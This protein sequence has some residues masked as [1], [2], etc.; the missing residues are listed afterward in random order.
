MGPRPAGVVALLISVCVQ[1]VGFNGRAWINEARVTHLYSQMADRFMHGHLT[2]GDVSGA[3]VL[4]PDPVWGN[5]L[6]DSSVYQGHFYYYWGPTPA[7]LLAGACRVLGLG[8][9]HVSDLD[10]SIAFGLATEACA[11]LLI[12]QIRA[13]FFPDQR[14][15][16]PAIMSLTL[17][18]PIL[19][20]LVYP[21]INQAAIFA[22]QFFVLAG[23]VAA[24][25][26]LGQDQ[27]RPGW[28]AAAG[29]S[30]SLAAGS[31]VSLPPA[32]LALAAVTLWKTWRAA[33][34]LPAKWKAAVTLVLP[35]AVGLGMLGWY[36]FARFGSV[37]ECGASYQLLRKDEPDMMASGFI[38]SGNIIPNAVI[39]LFIPPALPRSF[40][41]L[42]AFPN[43]LLSP[44]G[45][46]GGF[47]SI[48]QRIGP[49][50]V[51]GLVWIQPFLI[52]GVL[53]SFWRRLPPGRSLAWLRAALLAGGIGGAAAPLMIGVTTLRYT[54][55]FVPCLSIVAAMGYFHLLGQLAHRPVLAAEVRS[56]A[57]ILVGL[58]FIMAVLFNVGR[59]P[60]LAHRLAASLPVL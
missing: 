58:Q 33:P 13:R 9:P 45:L 6:F 53:A 5:T 32:V 12:L 35:V 50:A 16:V 10:L 34:I 3:D 31:R 26:A 49:E 11:V 2:V 55:D 22:G 36:N 24:W 56:A 46:S 28:L 27:V 19:F 1:C 57:R 4:H 17:G 54:L 39:Y 29:V 40:P 23:I 8:H 21:E 38:S 60:W 42:L 18:T 47:L 44:K 41:Y 25:R 52:A 14:S 20:N 7:V 59:F 15:V 51:V 37:W 48:R 43:V 30:W